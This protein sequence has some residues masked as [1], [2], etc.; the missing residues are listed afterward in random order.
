M[1]IPAAEALQLLQKA[2]AH[3]RLAHAYLITG[4]EGS[5][6]RQ[7]AAQLC[8]MIVGDPAKGLEHPDVHK[9][10]PES[11]SRRIVVDQIRG[12]EKQLQMRS[13]SGGRKVGVILD[14]DRLQQQASNAFLKTLEEPPAQS[15]LVLVT[16][17]PD[18]LLETILSRCIEVPLRA[19]SRPALTEQQVKLLDLLSANACSKTMGLPQIFAFVA[20]FQQLLAQAKEAA[21]ESISEE[22]EKEEKHYKQIADSKWFDEREDYFKALA[23]ARYIA[24]RTRLLD[25]LEQWWADV[26]RHQAHAGLED[27]R[28]AAALLDFPSHAEETALLAAKLS[29]EDAL[30]RT[31]ALETLREQLR[32][33]GI[34]EALAIE[35]SFLRAFAA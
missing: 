21:Q 24:E 35:V 16:S 8:G 10:E 15:H 3:S 1:A 34:R 13:S 2:N 11:K 20:E 17:L 12:L 32:N 29:P 4:P 25:T 33:T 7:L 9:I 19:T 26:L 27:T 23:E 6:K 22:Q 18:Q 28:A 5:G 30:R 31:A 14:A